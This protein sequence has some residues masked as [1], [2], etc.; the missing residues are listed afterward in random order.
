MK[1]EKL[2]SEETQVKDKPMKIFAR[3]L[4]LGLVFCFLIISY[5]FAFNS[6]LYVQFLSYKLDGT[7]NGSYYNTNALDLVVI[8][9]YDSINDIKVGDILCYY[10][11]SSKSSGMVTG[12]GNGVVILENDSGETFRVGNE[13]IVGKQVKTIPFVGLFI[14]ILTSYVGV[15]IFTCLALLFCA[16]FTFSRINYENTN[17]GKE[18]Y[19]KYRKSVE[20]EKQRNLLISSIKKRGDMPLN[21]TEVLDG[22]YEHNKDKFLNIV[23]LN[24]GSLKEKYKY[25]LSMVYDAYIFTWNLNLKGREI[26]S[27]VFEL[28][29]EAGEFDL[30]MEYM[31]KDLALKTHLVEFDSEAFRD[32]SFKFIENC[33]EEEDLIRFISVVYLVLKQNVKLRNSD[34][35][36]VVNEFLKKTNDFSEKNQKNAN[37]L[38]KEALKLIKT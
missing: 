18:L 19:R 13:R 9:K 6:N 24:K 36:F 26:I 8:E 20:D 14:Y 34:F 28:M 1:D 30:D 38:A 33:K 17:E 23:Y 16:L 10:L 4:I 35:E 3:V 11:V 5:V 22:D 31:L 29:C 27:N 37:L 2:S 25:L 15:L 7:A 21:I 12:F 32:A